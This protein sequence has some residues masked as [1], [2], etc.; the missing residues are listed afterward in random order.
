MA[1]PSLSTSSYDS[2]ANKYKELSARYSGNAGVKNA[3]QN[4]G[5]YASRAGSQAAAS[6]MSG[7]RSAGMSKSQAALMAA[8][9]G[10]KAATEGFNSGVNAYL[11][12]GQN[13]VTNQG[14]LLSSEYN[15]D[16][17]RDQRKL[18]KKAQ[19]WRITEG[20]ATGISNA[21]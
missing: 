9:A 21:L 15:K 17:A 12:S 14:Q 13:A 5:S 18:Q 8:N 16:I 3:E 11:Q 19:P 7:A 6:A 1:V 2:A 4:A 20:V 10:S